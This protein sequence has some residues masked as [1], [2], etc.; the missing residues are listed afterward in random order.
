MTAAGQEAAQPQHVTMVGRSDDHR[1][2]GAQLQQPHA[3]QDQGAHD[4][5][6]EFRLGDRHGS[7]LLRRNDQRLHRLDGRRVR[8]GGPARQL[9]ELAHERPGP[10]RGDQ[11]PLSVVVLGDLHPSGQDHRKAMASL[12]DP[13]QDLARLEVTDLAKP[14]QPLDLGRLQD[15]KGLLPTGFEDRRSSGS[16][17]RPRSA[18]GPN[19]RSSAAGS[20]GASGR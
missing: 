3:A 19:S 4:P 20:L 6:P 14:A 9:G 16:H 11:L 7:Q 17:E 13:A 1:P 8:Q 10:V 2:A 18:P 5:L 15:G 12:P